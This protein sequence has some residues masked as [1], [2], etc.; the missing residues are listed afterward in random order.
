[1]SKFASKFTF[2]NNSFIKNKALNYGGGINL[3]DSKRMNL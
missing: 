3:F 2:E 1:M